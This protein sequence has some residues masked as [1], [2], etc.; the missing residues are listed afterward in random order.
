MGNRTSNAEIIYEV[1]FHSPP[2]YS[3]FIDRF[4]IQNWPT[5]ILSGEIHTVPIELYNCGTLP[6]HNF[7]VSSPNYSSFL[8]NFDS[9]SD[10]TVI[11]RKDKVECLELTADTNV[12]RRI[13]FE[14]LQPAH[15]LKGTDLMYK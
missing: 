14:P 11:A 6:L 7:I 13:N 8:F 2:K 12:S 1:K 5:H 10:S 4:R 15:G 9:N 3:V